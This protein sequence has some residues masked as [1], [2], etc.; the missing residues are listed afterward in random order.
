M[1]TPEQEQEQALEAY[2]E[3]VVTKA[4]EKQLLDLMSKMKESDRGNSDSAR[5]G[6]SR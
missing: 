5:G 3:A 4:L 6:V 1:S 2:I